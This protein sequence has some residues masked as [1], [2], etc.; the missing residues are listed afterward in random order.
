MELC[1]ALVCIRVTEERNQQGDKSQWNGGSGSSG[2]RMVGDGQERCGCKVL[3]ELR[4]WPSVS[5]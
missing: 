3:L 2:R 1:Q 4:R 5:L